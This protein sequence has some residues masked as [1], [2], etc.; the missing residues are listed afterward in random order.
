MR[1]RSSS[2]STSAVPR[3][4]GSTPE[5][6]QEQLERL[7]D[8]LSPDGIIV[9]DLMTNHRARLRSYELLAPMI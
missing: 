4:I 9:Q 2:V 1:S 8:D 5:Q 7:I 3:L 6:V